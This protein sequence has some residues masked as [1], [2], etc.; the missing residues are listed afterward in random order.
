M[1]LI[2]FV[3]SKPGISGAGMDG[4]RILMLNYEYPPLGEAGA[5]R[6]SINYIYRFQ[7]FPAIYNNSINPKTKYYKVIQK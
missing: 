6:A 5:M 1:R 4:L 7:Y 2:D 3:F